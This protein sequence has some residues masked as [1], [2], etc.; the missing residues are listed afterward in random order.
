[1]K[2]RSV[3]YLLMRPALPREYLSGVVE[4]S[5]WIEM[6]CEGRTV[7]PTSLLSQMEFCTGQPAMFLHYYLAMTRMT[8]SAQTVG[9]APD[10]SAAVYLWLVHR[11]M[12]R[13]FPEW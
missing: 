9:D 1:M 7:E 13:L 2:V 10:E 12:I 11:A 8:V 4:R 3:A 6:Y 5:P